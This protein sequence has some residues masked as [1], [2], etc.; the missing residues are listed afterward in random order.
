MNVDNMFAQY[1]PTPAQKRRVNLLR[2]LARMLARDIRSE[3]PAGPNQTLAIRHVEDALMRA[4]KAI[5]EDALETAEQSWTVY[6]DLE[7]SGSYVIQDGELFREEPGGTYTPVGKVRKRLADHSPSDQP[8]LRL[9]ALSRYFASSP[10]APERRNSSACRGS[11]YSE[12]CRVEPSVRCPGSDNGARWNFSSYMF[13]SARSSTSS[14]VLPSVH[15][16][17]PILRLTVKSSRLLD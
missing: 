16:A 13:R 9:C 4:H 6:F 17:M 8:I 11:F 12:G 10:A 7:D 2:T 1:T 15:S 14:S 3:T 5:L